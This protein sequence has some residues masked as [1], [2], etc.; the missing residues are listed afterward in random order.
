M[1]RTDA[2]FAGSIPQLYDRYLGP[3]LFA[4]YAADLAARL[5]GL[6]SGR[7]LEVAAGTGILTAALAALPGVEITATDLNQPMLDHAAAKPGWPRCASIRPM[8]WPCPLPTR[9]S[10]RC[11]ASSASCSSPI[12][13]P[14]SARRAAS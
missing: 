12:V 10:T 4:P 2:V 8:R 3:T 1:P 11:Y 13:P 6:R 7:L 5:T 14:P 9:A